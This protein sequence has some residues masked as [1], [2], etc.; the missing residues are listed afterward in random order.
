MEVASPSSSRCRNGSGSAGVSPA[1][2]PAAVAVTAGVTRAP[3][4][5]SA[6]PCQAWYFRVPYSEDAAVHRR[7][8]PGAGADV[9][10]SRRHEPTSRRP[11]DGRQTASGRA[12]SQGASGP[13]L[14]DVTA[15]DDPA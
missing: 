15:L 10:R 2:A 11:A 9:G 5:V 7:T 8:T 14:R 3:L 6:A 12:N 13:W 1:T 4:S